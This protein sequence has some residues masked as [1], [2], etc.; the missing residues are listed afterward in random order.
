MHIDYDGCV[1]VVRRICN[2]PQVIRNPK[3]LLFLRMSRV[4]SVSNDRHTFCHKRAAFSVSEKNGLCCLPKSTK[5]YFHAV[6]ILPQLFLHPDSIQVFVSCAGKSGRVTS[7]RNRQKNLGSSCKNVQHS[8]MILE[9][10]WLNFDN[11]IQLSRTLLY[12]SGKIKGW[13]M[14]LKRKEDIHHKHE[15]HKFIS[16]FFSLES[17][18]LVI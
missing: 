2:T 18:T 4:E 14:V 13:S 7:N 3:L 9:Q 5:G 6:D 11:H 8:K 17:I 12:S 10:L 16:G 1:C 15:D